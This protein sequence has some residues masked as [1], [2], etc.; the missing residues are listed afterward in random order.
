MVATTLGVPEA[1]NRLLSDTLADFLLPKKLLLILD[2]CEHL[3]AACAELA[4]HLLEHC[5][6]VRLL[7][8]SREPLNLPNETVWLVPSLVLPDPKQPAHFEQQA[9]SEA[10]Q[11]FVARARTALPSFALVEENAAIV[12]HICRRL[13]G[14]PLAIELAAARV[15]LLDVVQIADRLDD[16]CSC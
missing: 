10:V 1:R 8:T 6:D 4:Q 16:T 3:L 9:K 15:K 11:L 5:P 13:D 14:I 2:N 12:E 7:A